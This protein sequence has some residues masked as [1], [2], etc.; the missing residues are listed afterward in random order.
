MVYGGFLVSTQRNLDTTVRMDS[1]EFNYKQ[2]LTF[3]PNWARGVQVFANASTQHATGGSR[4]Q[5]QNSPS[6]VNGG[7]S[8]TRRN[9]SLRVDANH[10]GRQ[11]QNVINGRGIQADTKSFEKARTYLD[12]TGEHV[13][14]RQFRVFAKL[15]NL[16][17]EG[18]DIDIYGPLTPLYARFQSRQRYGSLWTF[19]V[20]GTF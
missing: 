20:K 14:W 13:L 8:L 2:A 6:L 16:T 7:V 12:I 1:L 11:F 5:F 9:F 10:R 3:L 4:D 15:R 18:V 17:D 19:G